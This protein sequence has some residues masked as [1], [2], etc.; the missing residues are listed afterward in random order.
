MTSRKLLAAVVASAVLAPAGLA[1]ADGEDDTTFDGDGAVYLDTSLE[2]SPTNY[3][4]QPLLA[5]AADGDLL[6]GAAISRPP[7]LR[8]VTFLVEMRVAKLNENGSL[9]TGWGGGDGIAS[10]IVGVDGNSTSQTLALRGLAGGGALIVA[11][12]DGS[13]GVMSVRYDAAGV[14]DGIGQGGGPTGCSGTPKLAEILPD[15]DVVAVWENAC[16]GASNPCVRGADPCEQVGRARLQRYD[17]DDE[18]DLDPIHLPYGI[19]LT[20]FAEDMAIDDLAVADDGMASV[21]GE[22]IFTSG[23]GEAS[24]NAQI[25]RLD[26]ATGV[27]DEVFIVE[28]GS[29]DTYTGRFALRP[30]GG[31]V[32]AVAEMPET[33]GG[34]T[35][36]RLFRYT[37]DGADDPFGS[38][39]HT[40]LT[41]PALTCPYPHSVKVL[42]D[43]R[44]LLFR[45][46]WDDNPCA[47]A[48]VVARV[49][50][51][52]ELDS[53][54]DGDG[55][56]TFDLPSTQLT[57][58]SGDPL[59][60]PDGR[61]VLPF[62]ANQFAP[63]VDPPPAGGEYIGV[64]RIGTPPAQPVTQPP[65]TTQP[66]QTATTSSA[67]PLPQRPIVVPSRTCRSRR[68]LRIRL[69][70]GRRRSERSPIV[71]TRVTVNGRRVQAR[72]NGATVNLRNLPRG[73]YTVVIRLRLADG[74][75]VRD[76][77]R[78]RTCTRKIERELAPLRTRKPR[79]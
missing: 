22:I 47:E 77:R 11:T 12:N 67:A 52:G 3:T 41:H 43:E 2:G 58:D 20:P 62:I 6:V 13:R 78:Y 16:V 24:N 14:E 9:D 27:G 50:A 17:L 31:Y 26:S 79:S 10:T 25:Y 35:T 72:R 42:P 64:F 1:L 18:G 55:V 48:A 40:T 63:R 65:T 46:R 68:S 74:G 29:P 36:W 32:V 69:R 37:E 56:R 70:T 60:L 15:G 57:S 45:D 61:V 75:T 76:V 51:A 39:I 28:E 33:R 66:V 53:T 30:G 71:S 38:D 8:G 59:P 4:G 19:G 7:A 5:R 34:D 73:R 21:L 23:R 49:T 44:V 54:F